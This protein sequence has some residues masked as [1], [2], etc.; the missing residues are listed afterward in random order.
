MGQCLIWDATIILYYYILYYIM[1]LILS[2]QLT[3]SVASTFF[4]F[5]LVGSLCYASGRHVG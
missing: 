4:S 2:K 1:T 5:F 3:Q